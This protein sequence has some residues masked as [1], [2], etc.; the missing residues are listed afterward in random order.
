M[1]IN[2]IRS[3]S[4]FFKFPLSL[5]FSPEDLVSNEK[6]P[7]SDLVSMIEFENIAKGRRGAVLVDVKNDRIPLVRTTTK[8]TKPPQKFKPIHYDIMRKIRETSTLDKLDFNNALIEMYDNTYSNM[9]FHSDQALDLADNSYIAIYS[10]Y[11]TRMN[12]R[13]LVIK[14]KSIE[15]SSEVILDDNSVILFSLSTNQQY[16]HK[17]ILDDNNVDNVWLGIT[18]RL[19]KTFIYHIDNV[20]YF[21]HTNAVLKFVNEEERK[22]FY[23]LRNEENKNTDFKYPEVTYTISISDLLAISVV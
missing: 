2:N 3:Q 16:L 6:S 7:F 21:D 23:K 22:I 18:F 4:A 9:G 13:K 12:Y 19:S 15:E 20:P 17:I 1:D 8:Y 10:C 14:N 5:S 11:E